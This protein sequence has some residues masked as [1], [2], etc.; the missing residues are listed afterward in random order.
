MNWL[1]C[2]AISDAS[3][4]DVRFPRGTR[5]GGDDNSGTIEPF[6]NAIAE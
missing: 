3:W 6:P 4:I 1:H 5:R 2:E